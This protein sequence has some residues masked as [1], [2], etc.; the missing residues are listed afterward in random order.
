MRPIAVTG[1]GVLSAAGRGAEAARAAAM[2]GRSGLDGLTLLRS[3]RCG[4]FPVAEVKEADQ[5]G[6]PR[7][8]LLGRVALA[9]AL[10]AAGLAPGAPARAA[11]GL[12]LGTCVGGMPES[13]RAVKTLLSGGSPDPAVW[14]H[15]ECASTTC[16]LAREAGLEGPAV[17]IS[18]ACSSGAQAI[19]EAA[20]LIDAGEVDLMAAGGVDALCLLT[21][22]GFA[23]LLAMDPRGCRPFDRSR[24][25]MSLGEGAGF[26]VLESAEH[27]RARGAEVLALLMGSSNTCDAYHPTAPD[28]TGKGVESAMRKAL[29]R[30][31]IRPGDVDYVNAHGT[32]TPDNDRA[33]GQALAR[34]FAGRIPPISSTKRVFG[35]TLA[36]TGAI[37]AAVSIL[38]LR[39]GFLPGTCGLVEIDPECGIEP[40]MESRPGAPR[41]VLSNSFGFG[42]NNTVLCFAR[43]DFQP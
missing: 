33:E 1:L 7:T 26:L 39:T 42:G 10:F 16:T 27:A 3:E 4:H 18:N 40:L 14:L 13:E 23:S 2:E 32:G 37:E 5:P 17:T 34:I 21:L 22:N 15:H 41:V 30:S 8:V 38:A 31:A 28:P 6:V 29:E 43:P 11:A 25:G 35:H 24:K 9:E 12:S 20:D 36:A 19:A